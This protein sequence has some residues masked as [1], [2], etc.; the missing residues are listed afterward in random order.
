MKNIMKKYFLLPL[1][2]L[3]LL[4]SC[5]TEEPMPTYTLSTTVSPTEGGKITISLQTTK[6]EIW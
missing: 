6:K 3:L 5:E 2:L 1:I 4:G